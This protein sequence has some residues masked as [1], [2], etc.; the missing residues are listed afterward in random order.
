MLPT[1]RA[2]AIAALCLATLAWPRPGWALEAAV[3]PPRE[4]AGRV[5]ADVQLTSVISPR[6]E[7]SLGRG[8]P[9]RL[10]LH[11][12]LWRRRR[13]WFDRMEGDFDVSVR[14]RYE[15]WSRTYRLEWKGVAPVTLGTIDSVQTFLTQPLALPVG[16]SE[17]LQSG[18]RYYLAV[19]ATLEPLTVEDIEEG[20]G[21]LSGE[22][23]AQG[24]SGIGVVTALP[25]S[26]FDAARN[27][28]GLGDERARAIS[29]DAIFDVGAAV[30]P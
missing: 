16:R 5:W 4:R 3:A 12:E 30:S 21:W 18:S 28:S 15:V 6:V 2:A 14:I 8:M 19:V 27:F 26:L 23:K 17:K 22:V 20:E 9:A 10:Q 25:R 11:V 13:L 7:Q 24:G 1:S 29:E